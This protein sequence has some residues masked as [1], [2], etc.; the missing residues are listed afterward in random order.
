MLPLLKF[1]KDEKEHSLNEAL[2]Y[3]SAL[4]KLTEEEKRE[5]LPSDMQTIIENRVGWARTYLK[6]AGLTLLFF[7][8]PQDWR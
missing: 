5:I 3:I 4:F 7:D 1:M 6:K 8:K 2:D